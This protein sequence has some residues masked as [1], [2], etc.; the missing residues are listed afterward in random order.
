MTEALDIEAIRVA[1]E[2]ATDGPWWFD[3]DDLMWRLHGVGGVI[4]AQGGIIPEQII[5]HQIL[6]APKSGTN[7]AEYWPLPADAAFIVGARTWLPAVVAAL[8]EARAGQAALD[9]AMHTVWL[10]SGKWRWT[11]SKMT[12][13]AR[14]A[15]VAAVLRYDRSMKSADPDDELLTRASLAWWDDPHQSKQGV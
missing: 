3:E 15:A 13:E 11:T 4:P 1:I 5:N 6:K 12:T 7:Y 14:E 10:D 2:A 9:E 8:E